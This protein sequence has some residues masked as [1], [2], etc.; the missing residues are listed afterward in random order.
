MHEEGLLT[1]SSSIR[2]IEE[3]ETDADYLG[4]HLSNSGKYIWVEWIRYRKFSHGFVD[5]F[6]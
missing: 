2:A 6:C 1:G 4:F 5:D 3:V